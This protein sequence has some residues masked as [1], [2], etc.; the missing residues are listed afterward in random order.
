[1]V[2]TRHNG[3]QAPTDAN[4]YC[5]QEPHLYPQRVNRQ[6]RV[7]NIDFSFSET[8]TGPGAPEG[9]R[10]RG[11]GR[12]RGGDR[13]E[14]RGGPGPRGDDRDRGDREDRRRDD[15]RDDRP[16]REDRPPRGAGPGRG[17]VSTQA[18]TV[19]SKK[20]SLFIL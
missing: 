13:G 15:R 20:V 8:A 2:I 14:R 19:I 7:L 6:K 17:R 11:G 5:F 4:T 3:R 9:R 16:P 1:M 18:P 10:G 12:G